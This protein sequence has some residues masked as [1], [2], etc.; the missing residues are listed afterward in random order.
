MSNSPD[1]NSVFIPIT[2]VDQIKLDIVEITR[3][4]FGDR[5]PINLIDS[6]S[7]K[8]P[9]MMITMIYYPCSAIHIVSLD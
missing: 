1:T 6:G 9:H 2:N 8:E 5:I 7:G 3:V 4:L